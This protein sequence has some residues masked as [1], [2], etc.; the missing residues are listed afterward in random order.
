[1]S[2]DRRVL[3]VRK[4]GASPDRRGLFEQGRREP[5]ALA[6]V[7]FDLDRGEILAVVGESGCGKS[8]L[9]RALLGLEPSARGEVLVT[10]A[11]RTIELL[12][13]SA[14]DRRIAQAGIGWV[15]QDP[16]ASLDPRASVLESV[17]EPWIAHR[18]ASPAAAADHARTA[19]EA[20]GLAGRHA[21][22]L[23][24]QLSGGERQRASLARALTLEPGLLLLDEPTSS[25]DASIAAQLVDRVGRLVRERGLAALWV[26]H[27]VALARWCAQRVLVL[28]AG[29]VVER[30]AAEHVLREPTSSAAQRLVQAA[31]W[32]R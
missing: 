8:T 11:G 32:S 21:V 12:S 5:F 13:A 26:T 19:I 20:S 28:D 27:D 14:A 29:R 31:D 10:H 4:L 6:D 9:L 24:H 1:M 18:A 2:A 3:S 23:P 22:R 15:A 16:G 7:S 25:L 30:G 17:A